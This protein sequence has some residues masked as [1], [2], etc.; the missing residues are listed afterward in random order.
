MTFARLPIAL[1]AFL[2]PLCAQSVS[3][4]PLA[5]FNPQPDPPGFG[6]VSVRTNQIIRLN[7]VC[8]DH[9]VGFAPPDPCHGVAMFHA[10]DGTLLR[11]GRIDLK[12]G[13]S[14]FLTFTPP[15][16]GVTG[17]VWRMIDP[18]WLPDPGGRSIPNVEVLDGTT[19]IAVRNVNPVAARM[20]DVSNGRDP[21]LIVGF[22]PQ[23]D[24][25]GF[26]L[27][28]LVGQ[29]IR[30]NA[31]CFDHQVGNSPPDPCSGEFMFHNA[32]GDVVKSGRYSLRAG[33]STS[34]EFAP[35]AV[36]DLRS[37]ITLEPC[38]LP[39]AGGRVVPTVEVVDLATGDVVREILP[40]VSRMSELQ[41]R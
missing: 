24:P 3:R 17:A 13:Q 34:L 1:V 22:N 21:G 14:G 10:A 20:S 2:A 25:P 33:E 23:P 11:S 36:G 35:V 15:S 41:Q 4:G 39:A 37:A 31:V 38:L 19:G 29:A 26:G 16:T 28:T 30:L 40:V 18:C 5:A 32:A 9:Q 12:P 8:F 6:L 27:V 7:V